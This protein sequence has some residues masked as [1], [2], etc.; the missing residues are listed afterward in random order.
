MA[1]KVSEALEH[2]ILAAV[3]ETAAGLHGIGVLDSA[4]MREFDILCLTAD[5]AM[6]REQIRAIRRQ[7]LPGHRVCLGR[8]QPDEG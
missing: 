6:T 8:Q 2:D 5:R 7:G 4:T 1:A 3:H